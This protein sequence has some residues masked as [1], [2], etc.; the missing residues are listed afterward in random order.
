MIG[1]YILGHMAVCLLFG[2]TQIATDIKVANAQELNSGATL[3]LS[4]QV[5]DDLAPPEPVESASDSLHQ[6]L[7]NISQGVQAEG[8]EIDLQ[9]LPLNVDPG[10]WKSLISKQLRTDVAGSQVGLESIL[11]QTL[12]NSE[13]VKV[14]RQ[15]PLIRQT[16]IVEADAAFDWQAFLETR[17][18][19]LSDPIG[20]TLTAGAG[21]GRFR[22]HH[23]T[24]SAG[25][26][27]R[28][29]SGGELEV[30]QQFGFQD[31]NSQ[32]F[33]PDPQGTSR[34]T[35]GF[36]QPL[37][38][39]RGKVY[40]TSLICLAKLDQSISQDEFNRQLQGHLLETSRAYWS[41]YLE[42]GVLYQKLRSYQ[43]AE[44]IVEWLK[45]RQAIDAT[46]S[47]IKAAT[48]AFAERR[49]D[50]VRATTAVRNAESRLRALVNDP[51]LGN[52]E[53]LE[54]IPID[55]PSFDIIP[56][57]IHG[58]I[59]EAVQYRPEVTQALKQ[60]QAAGI[61]YGMS[62][63]ELMP[64]LNLVTQV[65][66]A[67]L[68]ANGRVDR[69]WGN[70]FDQGEPGYTIG[71]QF[72]VPLGNRAANARHQRRCLELKQLQHQ[73]RTTLQTVELEV[74]V[75]VREVETSK[76]EL[77][78]K[79]QVVRA[80]E[81]QLEFL[82]NRWERLPNE[83]VTSSLMLENILLAQDRLTAAEFEY[84]KAQITYNLSLI[85]LRKATGTL[86]QNQAIA[87]R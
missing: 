64:V 63:H 83:D 49:S 23:W 70:Q 4:D 11:Y 6:S 13:Q 15:L 76:Q 57:S 66:V 86:F 16:S 85:N 7:L 34:L 79:E 17:W 45:K 5:P 19:D 77:I 87:T 29:L 26:R 20:N 81:D 54:L 72:E 55:T 65:Y 58:S 50:L 42:R 30:S 33:V 71:L 74:K 18:D 75:A 44:K 31:N 68:S 78:S 10:W 69:S 73:Y 24:G 2:L 28:T 41:L 47:Q 35:L 14:F 32:F 51:G 60:I 36:T 12:A 46:Q 22:D 9:N 38:R 8:T 80:R 48:A 61:R 82:V 53:S 1:K 21:I 3:A 27:K 84:L 62:K 59:T 43:R 67:G 37:M 39:G 52:F 40:N 25:L 56:V